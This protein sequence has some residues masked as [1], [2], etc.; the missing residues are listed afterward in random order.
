MKN[1][2]ITNIAEK[3]N[4]DEFDVDLATNNYGDFIETVSESTSIFLP[5]LD[6]FEIFK[7][8]NN[9]SKVN[10]QFIKSFI[11][12]EMKTL[13]PILK[14]HNNTFAPN[15]YQ[16]IAKILIYKVVLKSNNISKIKKGTG[17]A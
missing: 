14:S 1:I 5:I 12:N 15:D 11:L 16:I 3:I 7:D 10:L 9:S 13:I 8:L 2:T 4:E 17:L 6:H